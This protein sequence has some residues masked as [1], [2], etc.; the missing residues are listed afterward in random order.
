MAAILL[1]HN[2][3]VKLPTM[4]TALSPQIADDPKYKTF[5]TNCLRA[6][7]G[8]HINM[9][10]GP[11]E[12][13]WYQNRKGHLSTNI[14]AAYNFE[15][16]FTY[17]LAGWEGLAHDGAVWRDALHKKGFTTPPG[18][19]WLRDTGYPNSDTILVLY[20]STCY[21]LKEQRLAGKKPETLKELYNLQ[22]ASLQNVIK[23]IFRVVK[24][25]Y[26][27]LCTP[28]KFLIPTQNQIIL[29]CCILHNFVRLVE[30]SNADT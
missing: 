23:R 30:G 21:H 17:I 9:Y 29:A 14:L 22:H 5:F 27:I 4:D 25:K 8:T 28:S 19:F 1:L 2:K 15:I 3:V 16:E 18:K 26:Q 11:K 20:Q 6:L 24:H 12:Q 13:P 10:I 7:N